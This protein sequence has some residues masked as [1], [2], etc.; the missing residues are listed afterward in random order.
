MA[1]IAKLSYGTTT[2]STWTSAGFTAS[3]FN[4]RAN[5]SVVVA[6]TALDNDSG[7][8]LEAEVSFS[9]EVGGTMTATSYFSLYIL[10]LNQDGSTYG[11]AAATGTTPP[12]TSYWVTNASLKPGVTSGN[13]VVGTFPRVALPAAD[14]KFAI[15]N[16]S[17]SALDSSAAAVVNYRT[18]NRN[19]NG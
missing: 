3:D 2:G 11:D 8:D 1:D 6:T 16:N 19:L 13:A 9:I 14:F 17:G 5:G 10:P 12:A 18:V 7:L 15:V 4:S